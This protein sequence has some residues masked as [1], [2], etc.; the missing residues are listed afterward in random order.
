MDGIWT[1]FLLGI[2]LLVVI[3][4]LQTKEGFVSLTK[5]ITKNAT[6]GMLETRPTLWWFVDD[7]INSRSWLDFGARNT[8]EPNRG[9]L[10]VAL[11]SVKATQEK[12]F[13]IEVLLGREEVS[14]VIREAGEPVPAGIQRLPATLWRNWAFTTLLSV[15]GGLV[16]VGD[17]TLC[18]RPFAP[19]ISQADVAVF[20]M[21]NDTTYA[22]PGSNVAPSMWVG[23]AVKPHRP[24]WD[25][26]A[27]AYSQ[28]V[29]AG[30]TAWNAAEA[31]RFHEKVWVMQQTKGPLVLADADGSRR[32]D[33]K[34]RTLE[35]YLGKQAKPVD[36]KIVFS[37]NTL[38]VSMDGDRL[39][40]EYRFAWFPRMSKQQILES[41]FVW[42]E[43]AKRHYH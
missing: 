22:V 6:R 37:K 10:Q 9:Y 8:R 42:A 18:I 17:S 33:G 32:A 15:K 39:I 1:V 40:R 36:A 34:E 23:W 19:S 21:S 7:E 3:K 14:K 27:T 31:R 24:V 30:P 13:R 4:L 11:D 28:L 2:L 12:D 26:A 20:G 29:E 43:L 41:G 5:E 16:M 25:V 35:D 38:F